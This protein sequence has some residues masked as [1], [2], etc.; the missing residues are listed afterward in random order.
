MT[1]RTRDAVEGRMTD[2][3]RQDAGGLL[4]HPGQCGS[5]EKG[6]RSLAD[7]AQVLLEQL[8]VAKIPALAPGPGA[9][10]NG[11][12]DVTVRVQLRQQR[13]NIVGQ[14]G[15]RRNVLR[16]AVDVVEYEAAVGSARDV[17]PIEHAGRSIT[18]LEDLVHRQPAAQFGLPGR[19]CELDVQRA[20]AIGDMK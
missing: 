20:A 2:A 17:Q 5:G 4:L 8:T 9:A 19:F 14:F 6:R 1:G 3:D 13:H 12:R 10:S 15:P 11:L 16:D 18:G 7:G